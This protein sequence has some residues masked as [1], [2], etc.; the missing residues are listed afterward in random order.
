MVLKEANKG[1]VF[2]ACTVKAYMRLEIQRQQYL[3]PLLYGMSGEPH[4]LAA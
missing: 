4:F 2:T 3:T 1:K